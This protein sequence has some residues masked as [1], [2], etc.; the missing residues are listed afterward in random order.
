M[1]FRKFRRT[2]SPCSDLLPRVLPSLPPISLSPLQA[3]FYTY[4]PL[5]LNED[6]E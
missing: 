6:I 1:K 5:S 3:I 4:Y 2:S